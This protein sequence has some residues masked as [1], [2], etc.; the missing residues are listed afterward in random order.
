MRKCYFAKINEIV[1]IIIIIAKMKFLTKITIA[2]LTGAQAIIINPERIQDE[3]LLQI[4]AEFPQQPLNLVGKKYKEFD[5]PNE[6]IPWGMD[7]GE[8]F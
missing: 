8:L 4:D 7:R 2:A 6:E 3:S 5:M 1:F